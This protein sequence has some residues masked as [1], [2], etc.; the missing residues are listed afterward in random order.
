M[1]KGSSELWE[2]LPLTY[3]LGPSRQL[4][5]SVV[6]YSLQNDY[7]HFVLGFSRLVK[8]GGFIPRYRD[9]ETEL[10]QG[11]LCQKSEKI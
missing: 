3:V 4:L 2:N 7:K 6:I 1:L 8:V 10:P 5:N 11:E 9:E